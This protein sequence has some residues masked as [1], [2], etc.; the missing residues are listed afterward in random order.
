MNNF[1]EELV[2][3]IDNAVD[4]NN[5]DFIAA[6]D[7]VLKFQKEHRQLEGIHVSVDPFAKYEGKEETEM[8]NSAK[9]ILS[10]LK[11]R[12]EGKLIPVSQEELEKM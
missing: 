3:V 11:C 7:E 8:Q 12:A 10:V 1:D 6:L 2:K 5:G 9:E 4:N